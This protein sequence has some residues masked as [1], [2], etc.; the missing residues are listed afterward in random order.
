[1]ETLDTPGVVR[2]CAH[3]KLVSRWEVEWALY[4]ALQDG[5]CVFSHVELCSGQTTREKQ[6]RFRHACMNS[7]HADRR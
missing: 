2:V 3:V 6:D 5:L 1:M 7:T 4:E